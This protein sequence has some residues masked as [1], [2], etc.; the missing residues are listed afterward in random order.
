MR[1]PVAFSVAA[2]AL[3][4]MAA[5]ALLVPRGV[6]DVAPAMPLELMPTRLA[7]WLGS[8]Q[9]ATDVLP[10]DPGVPVHLARTYDKDGQ[11]LWI[12]VG[13]YPNQAEGRRPPARDLLFPGRGWS[14]LSEEVVTLPL[15]GGSGRSIPANLV[16]MRSGQ[17]RVAIL[18]WYQLQD[19]SI[20]SD[21]WYRATLLYNRLIRGRAEGALVRIATAMPDGAGP[22]G[23][24][25]VQTEFVRAFYPELLR[26]L[27][28]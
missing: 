6:R 21:H 8:D 25:A 13:Y 12:S 23:A 9:G 18:Y 3:L 27:P 5:A 26:R 20:A 17:R 14:D 24:V 4:A 15:D 19:H 2:L 28:R 22:Q 1:R 11:R 7:G 16:L 10:A